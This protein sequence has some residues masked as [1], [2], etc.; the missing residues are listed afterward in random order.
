MATSGAVKADRGGD[1]AESCRQAVG[2]GCGGGADDDARDKP[3]RARL[4]AF[5]G[6][7][8]SGHRNGTA[9]HQS[10]LSSTMASATFTKPAMLAPRT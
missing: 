10:V 7:I 8:G 1:E 5:L 9:G 6:A 4:Q 3:D 2:G